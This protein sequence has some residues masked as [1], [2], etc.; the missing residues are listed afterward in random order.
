MASAARLGYISM[1]ENTNRI[2]SSWKINRCSCPR[3]PS[4]RL[5]SSAP[6]VSRKTAKSRHATAANLEPSPRRCCT[7]Q[8]YFCLEALADTLLRVRRATG[9]GE[10]DLDLD[11]P[12][13]AGEAE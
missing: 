1:H 2:E 5:S 10:R 6:R 9:D 4:Y 11:L 12:R 8:S 3:T 13:P 7:P